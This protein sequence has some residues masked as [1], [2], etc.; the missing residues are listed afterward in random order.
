MLQ[1]IRRQILMVEFLKKHPKDR[2]VVRGMSLQE[3]MEWVESRP[4]YNRLPLGRFE[5][6]DIEGGESPC[7]RD[8]NLVC[9]YGI[10]VK[11]DAQ[12]WAEILEEERKAMPSAQEVENAVQAILNT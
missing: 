7:P 2:K 12:E 8:E 10:M 3:A 6:V 5:I 4:S 11:S 1:G 9:I